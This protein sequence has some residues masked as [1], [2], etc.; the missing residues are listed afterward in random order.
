MSQSNEQN[1]TKKERQKLYKEQKK[2]EREQAST[3]K[4]QKRYLRGG[5]L[6]VAGVILGYLGYLQMNKTAN[7]AVPIMESQHLNSLDQPHVAYNTNP[8]TSGPHFEGH[9]EQKISSK[10]IPKEIQVHELEHGG[11][12]IQYNCK[13]CDDLIAKLEKLARV[14]EHVVLAPYPDMDA[15]IALTAWGKLAKLNGYDEKLIT[16]FINAY[17]GKNHGS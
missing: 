7:F 12:L 17:A 3:T 6:I 4:K 9:V 2:L 15:K 1:F 16:E 5:I 13:N 8:P 14:N 10:S 11:I